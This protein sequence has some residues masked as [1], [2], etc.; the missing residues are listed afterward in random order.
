MTKTDS[1][2]GHAACN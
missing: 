2:R 1:S